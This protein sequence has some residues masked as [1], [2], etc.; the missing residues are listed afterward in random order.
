MWL[1][2]P[3]A[4]VLITARRIA[5]SLDKDGKTASIGA[6]LMSPRI[7]IRA[8]AESAVNKPILHLD[9]DV[10]DTTSDLARDVPIRHHYLIP[11]RSSCMWSAVQRN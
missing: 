11:C 2:E 7:A 5:G 9:S 1:D 4:T 3:V 10:M 8:L 6:L